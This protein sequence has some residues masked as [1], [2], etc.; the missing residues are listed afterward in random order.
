M[1]DR[2]LRHV[3]AFNHWR[4]RHLP[5]NSFLII[6]AALVGALGGLAASAL[7][8]LTHLIANY[9]Q[10]DLQGDY[11]FWLYFCFP[12]IGLALTTLYLKVF[13]RRKPFRPGITPLIDSILHQ[14][15]RLDLHNIYSQVISSAL[16]VGMGGSA[17]LEAP[18]VSSGA[19]MGSNIG[20]L[21]GLNYRETTLLLACGGAAGISGA[22]GSPIAGMVFALEVLLPA[23]TIPAII[24]LLLASAVASVVSRMVYNEPLFAYVPGSSIIDNFWV[25]VVFGIVAGFF[26]V[27]YAY[28]NETIHKRLERTRN[29]YA[30]IGFG[31]ISL[32]AMIALFPALYGE[33]YIT[34]QQLLDNNYASLL[35]NSL[36][37]G[38]QGF[39]WALL[40]FAAITLLFKAIAPALTMGSGG[41]GGMFGPSV[42][43]GG[44]LGFVYAFGLNQTGLFHLNVKH[45]IVVGMAGSVSG[46]MHA[47][48]TGVFLAAE[49]TGGYVLM[50]PLMLV[51]AIS[52]VINKHIRKYSL[53]TKAMAEEGTLITGENK[54]AGLLARIRLRHLMVPSDVIL[55][56][57]D[58][59]VTRRDDII[60]SE[61]NMFPV[62]D[63]GGRL[64]GTIGIERLLEAAFST[65]AAIRDRPLGEVA[66]PNT[67][68]VRP[69]MPV[70][71]VLVLMNKRTKHTLPVV[72]A[73]GSY[74]GYI[75]KEAIFTQY[76]KL[77]I[78]QND[79]V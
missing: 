47:P 40:L 69:D 4:K 70:H 64:L 36:F 10:N 5:Q 73:Q 42:V 29:I 56:P 71:E 32:G 33:G 58:T 22:F 60:H 1:P 46:M 18:S 44:L 38:Y 24:P 63:G 79:L 21:F 12:I 78:E 34:I 23:F 39:A 30:K 55:A 67:E 17:G 6:A 48:L 25:Y 31:G 72:D 49:I 57:A 35:N 15:S 2:L 74:L 19:S 20:R 41:N 50:V 61:R 14:R 16:T 52:Y 77:L 37:A 8:K 27:Y 65:D 11:K 53:Y 3:T 26:S 62:V 7:K 43:I 68:L 75:S 51:S 59:A 45:F 13:I 54:D 9:L 28:M 66:Q 76:R